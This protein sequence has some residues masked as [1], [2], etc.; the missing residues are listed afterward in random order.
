ME[1]NNNQKNTGNKPEIDDIRIGLKPP[2]LFKNPVQ[3]WDV[4][5]YRLEHKRLHNENFLFYTTSPMLLEGLVKAF[6]YQLEKRKADNN[7]LDGYGYYEFGVFKGFS[8]WF[9]QMYA[10]QC[11]ISDFWFY[12]FDSF[13]GLPKSKI[14]GMKPAFGKGH[15]A[16][17]FEFVAE[18]LKELD[19]DFS[20]VKLLKGFYS[21]ELFEKF[22]RE[23]KFRPISICVID[24]DIYESCVEVLEFIKDFLVPGSIILFD[25]YNTFYKSEEHSERKALREFEAKYPNF[26][27][28]YLFD[29]GWHGTAF[30]VLKI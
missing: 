1:E 26:Q 25:D 15:Y 4:L 12:G 10:K 17:S 18:K 23:N 19:V 7:L 21:K 28:K 20:K 29:F 24:V 8:L 27:K 2:S 6:N 3:W 5:K 16:A 11:S 13:A 22:K 9:S 14:D 30:E